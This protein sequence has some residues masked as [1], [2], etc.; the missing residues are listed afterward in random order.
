V[1]HRR[2][3]S[4]VFLSAALAAGCASGPSAP[5]PPGRSS[6]PAVGGT[7]VASPTAPSAIATLGPGKQ[8]LGPATYRVELASAPTVQNDAFPALLITLPDGWANYDGWAM[9]RGT[10]DDPTVAVQ[11]WDIGLV[12]GHPCRWQGTLFRP[13]PTVDDLVAALVDRPLRNA[14]Q[15]SDVNLDGYRGKYLEW[16]V[17]AD[18]DFFDCDGVSFKSWTGAMRGD[19]YQQGPGQV[20]RLWILDVEGARLV[21]DAFSMPSATRQEREELLD[22]VES[23]RFDR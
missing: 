6:T 1:I 20:D 2:V 5:E 17:P 18:L 9:H 11:F 15:P 13:G 4:S 19:R 10:V 16:S 12:Y 22:V 7:G 8:S 21:I 14:T 23:I 3:V